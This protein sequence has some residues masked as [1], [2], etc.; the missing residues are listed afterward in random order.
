M[1]FFD[2]LNYLHCPSAIQR[3]VVF[4][5]SKDNEMK[6][7]WSFLLFLFNLEVDAI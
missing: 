5:L 1:L 4:G 3:R 7:G 6:K 2:I